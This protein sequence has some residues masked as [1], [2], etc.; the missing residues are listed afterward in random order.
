MNLLYFDIE[1][2]G[3]YK[4]FQTFKRIDPRGADLFEK[5]VIK[6]HWLNEKSIVFYKSI[7]EA[8]LNKAA[9]YSEFNIIVCITYGYEDLRD[10]F[11]VKTLIGEEDQIIK[12]SNKIWSNFIK[13]KKSYLGCGYNIKRFDLPLLNIKHYQHNIP[14]PK[15]LEVKDKKPWEIQ[16][17]DIFEKWNHGFNS[18]VSLDEV[19]YAL[20]IE[21]PRDIMSGS[22]V[23][24]EYYNGNINK[25]VKYCEGDVR[26]LPKIIERIY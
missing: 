12:D 6:H 1:T 18:F 4:D 11:R 21:S 24:N 20:G 10:G 3:K 2:A 16:H 22:D 9:L 19:C 25:I 7:D 17:I 5:K 26:V 14:I 15:I 8:Y 23:H 13:I